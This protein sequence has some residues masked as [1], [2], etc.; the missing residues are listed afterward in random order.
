VC[1]IVQHTH[2]KL[3]LHRDIT[4]GHILVTLNGDVK[5]LDFGTKGLTELAG[6]RRQTRARALCEAWQADRFVER[7]RLRQQHLGAISVACRGA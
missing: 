6:G 2:K 3:V 5:L 7:Q 1:A 4:P